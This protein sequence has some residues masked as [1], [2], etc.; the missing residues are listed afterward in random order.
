V[1]AHQLGAQSLPPRNP[2]ETKVPRGALAAEVV[3]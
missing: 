2:S 1:F 3:G